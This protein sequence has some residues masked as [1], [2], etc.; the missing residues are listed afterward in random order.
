MLVGAV[1]ERR[2]LRRRVRQLHAKPRAALVAEKLLGDLGVGLERVGAPSHRRENARPH[3]RS[4]RHPRDAQVHRHEGEV[5]DGR[6]HPDLPEGDEVLRHVLLVFA[7]AVHGRT[8]VD[9]LLDRVEAREVRERVV[10][11]L[12]QHHLRE[13]APLAG[14][15]GQL[16]GDGRGGKGLGSGEEPREDG[17]V[18]R[19][20]HAAQIHQAK[21]RERAV[22][23]P[24]DTL[25]PFDC[26]LHE[27]I[28]E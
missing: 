24:V 23:S 18:E 15:I 11:E 4:R 21:E 10:D 6:R 9:Q 5:D 2:A 16:G 1:V 22:A 12:V 8:A 3:E 17:H 27:P 20:L 14:E 26:R 19:V 28:R 13:H 25:P 7:H